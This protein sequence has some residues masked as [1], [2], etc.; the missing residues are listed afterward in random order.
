MN[1][2]RW[3]ESLGRRGA[4]RSLIGFLAASPLAHGQ[5]DPFRDHSRVP[6]LEELV[7]AF[8]F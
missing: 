7:D 3:A 2:P 4:L 1:E 6:R 5:Q 8:D